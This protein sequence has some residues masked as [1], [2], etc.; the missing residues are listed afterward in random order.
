VLLRLINYW[1]VH[2][3]E[4]AHSTRIRTQLIMSQHRS[5]LFAISVPHQ[6]HIKQSRHWAVPA[7]A[8]LENHLFYDH[9]SPVPLHLYMDRKRN[10]AA[11]TIQVWARSILM[12]RKFLC[13]LPEDPSSPTL[14]AGGKIIVRNLFV[15]SLKSFMRMKDNERVVNTQ[16]VLYYIL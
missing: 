13:R 5:R 14:S 11:I 8:Y 3:A 16:Q 7:D 4:F 2:A 12:I 9:S 10:L 15:W 1:N 6:I